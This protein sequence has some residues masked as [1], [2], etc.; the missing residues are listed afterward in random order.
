MNVAREAVM[1][2]LLAKLQAIVFAAPVNGQTGFATTSRRLKLWGDVPK[3]QRPALFLTEHREQPSYQAE[4]QPAKTAL[5]VDLFIYIDSGD[6][7]TVPAIALNVRWT[8]S[9]PR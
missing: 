6:P 5:S 1:A 7:N 9:K 8:R 4:A 3:S 2:A